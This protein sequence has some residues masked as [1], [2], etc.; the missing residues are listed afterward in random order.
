MMV[1]AVQLE[2]WG[3]TVDDLRALA[4]TAPHPRTRER[5]LALHDIAVGSNATQVAARTGRSDEAVLRWLHGYNDHGPD[6]VAY[7]HTGGHPPLPRG[8]KPPST[9]RFVPRSPPPRRHR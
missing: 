3:Q 9:R 6:A 5:F 8:S 7:R 2:R 1:V 4:L